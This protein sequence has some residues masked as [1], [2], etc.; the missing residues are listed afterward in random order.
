MSNMTNN[1]AF[2]FDW[3]SPVEKDSAEYELLPEGEYRFEVIKMERERYSPGPKSK[4]PACNMATLTLRVEDDA[5]RT[6]LE[7]RLYL[8]SSS[9][10]K[11]GQFF[12]SVGLKEPGKSY[13]P[14]WNKVVGAFGRCSLGIREW[15]GD[16]GQ[17]RKANQVKKYLPPEGNAQGGAQAALAGRYSQGF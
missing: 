14:E 7:D 12:V 2:A 17:T 4:I 5:K 9:E 11:I 16:D 13:V 1:T 10:W 15:V 8:V 6:T 3:D